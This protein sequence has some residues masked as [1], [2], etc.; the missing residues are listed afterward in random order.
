MSDSLITELAETLVLGALLEL[1]R[2]R[3][4]GY[5]LLAH[6]EQGEFHH[7]VVVAIPAG[8]ATFRYLVVATNCNGGVKEVLAFTAPPERG[9]LWHWRCPRVEDFTPASHFA[10]CGRA[11]TTHWFDPCELLAADA[12]SELRAEHRQRQHGGG[13]KKIGCG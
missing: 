9:T 8:A 5:E 12:R 4:G 6:W 10:L 3:V 1:L 2:A 7:D 11:V 13:W